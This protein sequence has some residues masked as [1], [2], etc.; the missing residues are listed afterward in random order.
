M[1]AHYIINISSICVRFLLWSV[2]GTWVRYRRKDLS[3]ARVAFYLGYD[4]AGMEGQTHTACH[5]D[6]CVCPQCRMHSPAP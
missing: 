3:H 2:E 6:V 4:L 1:S 5:V